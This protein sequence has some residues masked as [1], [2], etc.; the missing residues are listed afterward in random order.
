M[1]DMKRLEINL[2]HVLGMIGGKAELLAVTKS[3][4]VEVIEQLVSLG[5]RNFGENRVQDAEGKILALGNDGLKWHMIGHLQ[6]NKVKK[7][8]RLFD[9][10]QT[11]DSLK[12]A[13]LIDR[14][15][16]KIGKIID[17]LIQV[18]ISGEEQKSGIEPSAVPMFFERLSEMG[19]RNIRIIG[20]MGMPP[21]GG[22]EIARPYFRKMKVLFDILKGKYGLSTLSMG[23]SNDYAAAVEEG[24]NMV[25]V[26][27]MLFR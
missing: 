20:I 8:V 7:A 25:R 23:M 14:E 27:T 3:E 2:N 9:V 16:G 13:G 10:I 18:N 6:S 15:A 1:A 11:V 24:S 19:L 5:Q 12:L 22:S 17:A 21:F 26:G 4:G